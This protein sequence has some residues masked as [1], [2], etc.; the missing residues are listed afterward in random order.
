MLEDNIHGNLN[1]VANCLPTNS[2][3]ESGTA[4]LPHSSSPTKNSSEN[5]HTTQYRKRKFL[6]SSQTSLHH[7]HRR[8]ISLRTTILDGEDD[9]EDELAYIPPQSILDQILPASDIQYRQNSIVPPLKDGMENSA[10]LVKGHKETRPYEFLCK[11]SI[12]PALFL[13]AI[14][15]RRL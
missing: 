5:K 12:P 15:D 7:V 11:G 2:Q 6:T 4:Q 1:D 14:F 9:S 13:S 10:V 3:V 8:R